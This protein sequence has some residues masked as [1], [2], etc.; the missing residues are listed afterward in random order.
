MGT[1]SMQTSDMLTAV[2]LA[3]QYPDEEVKIADNSPSEVNY[4]LQLFGYTTV[5]VKSE[6]DYNFIV[7]SNGKTELT[8]IYNG[9]SWYVGL[10][11]GRVYE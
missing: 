1:S 8:M 11:K 6:I 3:T 10:K 4:A 2:A 9:W 7:Y 5:D